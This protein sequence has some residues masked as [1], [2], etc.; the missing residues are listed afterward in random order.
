MPNADRLEI[1]PLSPCHVPQ[2]KFSILLANSA[3]LAVVGT[4]QATP[5]DYVAAGQSFEPV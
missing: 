3:V 2:P 4:H 5:I 1:R